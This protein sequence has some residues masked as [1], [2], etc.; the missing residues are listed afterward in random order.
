[1]KE[2]ISNTLSQ[3]KPSKI[4]ELYE[5]YKDTIIHS[6]LKILV[7]ILAY[8][9]FSKLI[10]YLRKII[11]RTLE[12]SSL[13]TGVIQF[14]DSFVNIV[15][16]SLLLASIAIK[17]DI[18]ITESTIIAVLGS[19]G[20]TL[21]LALQG[22][23]SNFAGGVL[24][25]ILHPFRVGDYIIE[26]GDKNEGTV[27][28][29]E[30][31]YTTLVTAD[32]KVVTIPNGAL[33]NTSIVNVTSQ[34][35]RRLDIRVGIPYDGDL[36]L[37]KEILMQILLDHDKILATEEISVFVDE[38]GP[39]AVYL[40]CRAWTGMGDYWNCR[41]EIVESIKLTFDAHHITIAHSQ[42]DVHIK[43]NLESKES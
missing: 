1:M 43:N 40:G 32:N 9:I 38:L 8:F 5:Q 24:L 34:N 21:G 26:N 7:L 6:I 33:S 31:F 37:A 11:K 28:K 16:R 36:L 10:N 18:G 12:L 25:L 35:K 3:L 29:I 41:Y 22:S 23:L 17:L 30:L 19:A 39:D 13:D 42:L 27:E 14:I 4:A 15:L 20:L 2:E